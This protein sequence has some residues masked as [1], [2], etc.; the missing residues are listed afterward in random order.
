MPS[1]SGLVRYDGS[2]FTDSTTSAS[3]SRSSVS[4]APA[5]A[6]DSSS[7]SARLPAPGSTSTSYPRPVS[8]PTSSGTIATR[9]SPSRVSLTTAIFTG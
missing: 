3:V 1:R 6:Y 7:H 5:S 4:T 8:L 2:G 9:V